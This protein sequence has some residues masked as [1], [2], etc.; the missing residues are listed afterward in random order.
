MNIYILI[1]YFRDIVNAKCQNIKTETICEIWETVARRL[2]TFVEILH[3]LFPQI[4]QF[5][6]NSNLQLKASSRRLAVAFKLSNDSLGCEFEIF[7]SSSGIIFAETRSR[8]IRIQKVESCLA[9]KITLRKPQIRCS[10]QIIRN[11]S[12][13]T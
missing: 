6:C 3:L 1:I 5:N 13:S 2:P 10:N 7:E 8:I 4:P 12:A 11:R 9:L